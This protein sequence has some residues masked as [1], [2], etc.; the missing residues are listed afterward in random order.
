[1]FLGAFRQILMSIQL[2]CNC[3]GRIRLT[4]VVRAVKGIQYQ[5]AAQAVKRFATSLEKDAARQKFVLELQRQLS[6]I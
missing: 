5:A 4:E 6:L 2:T 1:M 3:F